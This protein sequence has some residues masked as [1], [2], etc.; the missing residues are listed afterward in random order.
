MKYNLDPHGKHSDTFLWSC[1]EKCQ[2]KS[3]VEKTGLGL[4]AVVAVGGLN[5][6][7][8]Q[9]QLICL[10]RALAA[11]AKVLVLDECSASVDK[12]T[13][14]ML[15]EMI[16]REFAECTVLTIAHRLETV[17]HCDQVMVLEKG[18]VVEY[19]A[20]EVLRRKD[21]SMFQQLWMQQK[22]SRSKS[23]TSS[24]DGSRNK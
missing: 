19:G 23:N 21:G 16:R 13:D 6:S 3:V 14:D 17:I 5:W 15:Q 24:S 12:E 4:M 7:V 2:L 18:K 11:R 1:L 10:A 8:G 9:R 20:P 22:E